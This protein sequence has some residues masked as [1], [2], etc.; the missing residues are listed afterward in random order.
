MLGKY[1]FIAAMAIICYTHASPQ[2]IQ[3]P[4]GSRAAGMAH[5]SMVNQDLWG[6]FNN[7]AAIAYQTGFSVGVS[8]ENRYLVKE[9]NRISTAAAFQ[10][11]RGGLLASIDHLGDAFYSEMKAGAGYALKLGS[12]IAAGM[13]IDYL[14]MSIGEGY[15][16][17]HAFTF[18]LG[19]MFL[20]NDKLF[21]GMH[22]FNPVHAGWTGT[23]EHIPVFIR[24]GFGYKPEKS[25]SIFAEI[26]KS[27]STQAVIAAG[28][29]YRYREK[30]FM[31]AGVSSGP[32]RIT[33][34]AGFKLK[35]LA[36]DIASGIHSYL[37]FSPC[38]SISY[39][40]KK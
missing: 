35:S 36:I 27:T 34:G 14:R 5:C 32:A 9:M 30:F 31:R 21:L 2:S 7:Q 37:G 19:M 24:A 39:N 28:C 33:F 20:L 15:G 26:M 4:V 13:Q 10:L 17:Y 3:L 29:E 18:E 40:S 22:C 23:D 16:S 25:I 6:V 8:L 1:L 12:R 11:G 38:I